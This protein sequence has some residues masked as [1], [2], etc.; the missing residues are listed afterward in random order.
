[1]IAAEVRGLVASTD[2]IPAPKIEAGTRRI[3]KDLF[4][5]LVSKEL[6]SLLL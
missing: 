6:L 2:Q 1:M 3:L 5:E 4:L